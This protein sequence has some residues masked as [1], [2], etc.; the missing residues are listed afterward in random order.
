[1]PSPNNITELI[2]FVV[3]AI[4]A[5]LLIMVGSRYTRFGR[6]LT[7]NWKSGPIDL[8]LEQLKR[9]SGPTARP[10]EKYVDPLASLKPHYAVG[11]VLL[12]MLI[13]FV[14]YLLTKNTL[15]SGN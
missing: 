5:V 7:G 4:I 6:K 10:R 12:F 13:V 2:I 15:Q 1:M 8:E 14:Y 11:G 9:T 3:G